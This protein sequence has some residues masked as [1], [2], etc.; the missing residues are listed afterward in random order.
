VFGVFVSLLFLRAEVLRCKILDGGLGILFLNL[1]RSFLAFTTFAVDLSQPVL[2]SEFV[3][4][5]LIMRFFFGSFFLMAGHPFLMPST[6]PPLSHIFGVPP[7]PA[8]SDTD[9][10]I[11]SRASDPFFP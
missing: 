8:S 5:T 3:D 1:V 6:P 2:L 10:F 9:S 7:L 4:L 11:S